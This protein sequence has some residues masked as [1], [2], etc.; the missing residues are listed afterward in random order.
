MTTYHVTDYGDPRRY[1]VQ[2][3]NMIDDLKLSPYAFRL[4]V[5]L[6]RVAG[7][8][9]QCWQSTKTL[10]EACNMS[11][12]TVTKAK[13][14]LKENNLIRIAYV[15]HERPGRA[16]HMITVEDIWLE[17]SIKYG[18]SSR[19]DNQSSPR[20]LYSSPS[21]L[22][23]SPHELKNNPIKK[24]QLRR[25]GEFILEDGKDIFDLTP[26][27]AMKVKEINVF[28][29]AT[30]RFPGHPQ[31]RKVYQALHGKDYTVEKIRSTYEEWCNRGYKPENIGWLDWLDDGI[32]ERGTAK[33][34]TRKVT[35]QD[36]EVVEIPA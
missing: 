5:H 18:Q 22:Q 2:I 19:S 28:R 26:L 34:Q 8:N 32:P 3:P 24:N 9:G 30:C 14:E 10:S 13:D 12:G 7:D 23:S 35:N 4:Y 29:T 20:E 25:E 11:A 15:E 33:R 31:W 27:E 36:G 21:E 16:Y 17:N 6:K 1:F